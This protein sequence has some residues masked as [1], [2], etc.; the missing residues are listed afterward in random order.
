MSSS[1]SFTDFILPN[2]WDMGLVKEVPGEVVHWTRGTQGK[3]V[4]TLRS[5]SSAYSTDHYLAVRSICPDCKQGM[6]TPGADPG[7]DLFVTFRDD[8]G[9]S[10]YRLEEKFQNNVYVHLRRNP[11]NSI[12][13][14][15]TEVL[16]NLSWGE[17]Y[18][19]TAIGFAV[20]FCQISAE[21]VAT[22]SLGDDVDETFRACP[23][24]SEENGITTGRPELP[25][26]CKFTDMGPKRI[27]G[28]KYEWQYDTYEDAQYKCATE[29][30]C[31]GIYQS[32]AGAKFEARTGKSWGFELTGSTSWACYGFTSNGKMVVEEPTD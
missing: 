21:G 4:F 15:G 30:T 2:R 14:L 22:V 9:Y 10:S 5:T 13:G 23:N 20:T 18:N 27:S 1:G 26:R 25:D 8:K 12:I 16:G 32:K 6:P 19:N 3:S 31:T 29:P 7:G 11:V 17:S 24:Y 28:F